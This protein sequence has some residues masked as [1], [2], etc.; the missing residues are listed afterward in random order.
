MRS[1]CR[2]PLDRVLS[3]IDACTAGAYAPVPVFFSDK[4][5]SKNQKPLPY[6]KKVVPRF[7]EVCNKVAETKVHTK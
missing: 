3:L 1:V 4:S 7:W 6:L 2:F 5:T